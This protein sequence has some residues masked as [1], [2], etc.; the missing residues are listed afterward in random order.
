MNKRLIFVFLIACITGCGI[1]FFQLYW[2][3]ASFGAAHENFQR[4]ATALLQHTIDDYQLKQTS[5]ILHFK[6]GDTTLSVGLPSVDKT[7]GNKSQ[8]SKEK[9][10][11]RA[12]YQQF[13]QKL[14]RSNINTVKIMM[15]RMI[16]QVTSKPVVLSALEKNYRQEL[17]ENKIGIPFT[18]SFIPPDRKLEKFEVVG[19]SGLSG[20][21]KLIRANFR[22]TTLTLIGF[23]LLPLIV[24]AG[25]ILLASGCLYYM[26][27]VI[28]KQ[29][30]LDD[31]KNDLINN[32]THE[33]RTPV[34]ILKSTHEAIEKFSDPS[35]FV[36]VMRYI[37]A[38]QSVLNKLEA[39]IDRILDV[40][41]YE[42]NTKYLI[43]TNFTLKQL[44]R[45]ILNAFELANGVKIKF[46][47]EINQETIYSDQ[48]VIATII[49]NLID[50]ALKYGGPEV[51]IGL[52]IY[53]GNDG[54][55]LEVSDNGP[56]IPKKFTD[57]IFDK[58]YRIPTGN[59]HDIKGYG[60][61][62]SY[63]K[64]L[65]GLLHGRMTVQS[66]IGEG[67]TFRIEFPSNE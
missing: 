9:G 27:H 63:V 44:V 28:R 7:A 22:L 10:A 55:V 24:S 29:S 36:N 49:S 16:A 65:T 46:T 25:L 5:E 62:L 17:L 23:N 60:I 50:N 51:N 42:N 39:N 31:L 14:T 33:F 40:T 67:T 26:W 2:L 21:S 11:L 41:G 53:P 52:G 37:S 48:F 59:V 3:S 30:L 12:G 45:D 6:P 20:K 56:G 4:T 35:E 13:E 38:N 1:V 32:L 54:W 15:A 8:P 43:L 64:T 18:L 19:Y 57:L 61:G 34:A 58:F 47:Y 66:K